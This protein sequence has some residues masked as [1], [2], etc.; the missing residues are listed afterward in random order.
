MA[1][2]FA[3]FPPG[4]HWGVA[5]SAYQIEGAW[6]E[7]GKGP[8][9]W[10][11]FS[12]T[13][14]RIANADTGDVACDHYHR[15]RE[16]L[17]LLRGLGVNAYRFSLSWPR[18]QPTGR[19]AVN[20]RGLAFYD[21]LVDGLLEAGIE[22]FVTL[23]HW[24]LPQALQD[25]GGWPSQET[26]GAFVEFA[27]LTARRLGDRVRFWCT[28]NEPFVAAILGYLTGEHAPGMRD[29][30]TALRA[31][32]HLLWSHG[33]AVRALRAAA[34]GP[35][36]VGIVLNLQPV[37]AASTARD[38][39]AAAQRCDGLAN[40]W[41]LEP[42]FRASYPADMLEY[43]GRAA[44]SLDPAVLRSI[45]AP[46]DFLGVNYYTCV[47]AQHNAER[48]GIQVEQVVPPGS[49]RS[50]LWE[51]YPAGLEELLARLMREYHPPALY[52]TEN[53]MPALDAPDSA[54]Q[55]EDASR[56]SFLERHLAAAERAVAAGVPLRG[57]FVWS[58]LDNFEWAYGYAMRFGLVYVDFATQ[59]RTVKASGHWYRD[60]IGR[61]QSPRS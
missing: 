56:I 7:D 28:H 39:Q 5:T 48:A 36:Q 40:R 11:S 53:G 37:L 9:I 60:M 8:S 33:E 26:V 25:V 58:L 30:A 27:E 29:V 23:Y 2:S 38:D 3:G 1:A 45:A 20:E 14:G 55:V 51:I 21:R 57:Y 49:E 50:V 44:P 47:V 31:A 46:I 35:L 18:V 59:Q 32:H 13:P 16:D 52:I 24:D 12:H 41:F 17:E 4:F 34:R 15:W 54:G 19:G 10:D 22:P 43:F 6:S 42:L 61:T